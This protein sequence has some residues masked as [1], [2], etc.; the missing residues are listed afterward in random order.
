MASLLDRK[1]HEWLACIIAEEVDETG[2]LRLAG[3]MMR[4]DPDRALALLAALEDGFIGAKK[5]P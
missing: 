3:D 1:G 2:Q 4:D 5:E